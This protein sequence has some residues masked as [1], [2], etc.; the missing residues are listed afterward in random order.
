[1]QAQRAQRP[2]WRL[3]AAARERGEEL[4]SVEG[5]ELEPPVERLQPWS[6][7]AIAQGT[8]LV[9]S[10]AWPLVH[11][12]SFEKVTGPK[13]EGWLTKGVGACWANVGLHLIQAGRRRGR[14]RRDI[15]GLAVRMALTFAAFDLYYAGVRRRISPVYLLNGF[16]QLG[17]VALWG[18]ERIAEARALARP[19]VA[20]HA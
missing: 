12:R 10:G 3:I 19:P 8:Y 13:P 1:M 11:L 6:K 9:L 17:F 5:I 7:L 18:L 15:R 4:R 20:A 16:V 14:A 2:G